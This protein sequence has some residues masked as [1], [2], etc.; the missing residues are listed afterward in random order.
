[1]PRLRSGVKRFVR[2]SGVGCGNSLKQPGFGEGLTGCTQDADPRAGLPRSAGLRDGGNSAGTASARNR[3]D[4]TFGLC[5]FFT[6]RP[7]Y[8]PGYPCYTARTVP[9]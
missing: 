2:H 1:M 6:A 7:L 9:A 3:T 5:P 8:A 4:G